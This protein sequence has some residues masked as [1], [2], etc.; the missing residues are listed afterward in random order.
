MQSHTIASISLLLITIVFCCTPALSSSAEDAIRKPIHREDH[1]G[2]HLQHTPALNTST[3]A[4]DLR[5]LLDLAEIISKLSSYQVVFIGEN[6]PRYDQ[7]LSQLAIIRGL[8]AI[9]SDLVIGV[10]FVQQPLQQ[11][12]DQ[13]I[14][15]EM[16]TREFLDKIEY[17]DRW[18]YDFRLYAPIFEFARAKAIPMLALNVPTEIIQKV[19]RE[20]LK[21]LS[22]KERAQ[23]PTQ[24]DRSSAKYRQRLKKV[25]ENHPKGFGEFEA[26]YEAQ[27]VWDESMAE[28]AA[29]YMRNYPESHMV[30]LAGNG[31]LAHGVGIPER[32]SRR[33][34]K[35]ISTAVVLNGWTGIPEPGLAD[36]LL[37]SKERE[38]P[39]P[40]FLGVMLELSD[41][42]LMISSF[43]ENSAAK[44]AGI[45]EGDELLSLNGYAVSDIADVKE[46]MW[47]KKPGEVVFV[48]V[49]RDPL[50]GKQEE[51]KFKIELR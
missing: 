33:L 16:S 45:K 44:A 49:G 50:R 4:V 11:Y 21:G 37:F 40:G 2:T 14:V 47:D 25:Y 30:I 6:H 24:I 38:L 19:G 12:L 34:D 27:L 48:R 32:F 35:S 51:K 17:Y 46:I 42:K 36:Y 26:F 10:E 3:R 8:Y 15:G 18:R 9:H 28:R 31:H 39:E 43:S 20:G 23:L 22:K 29:S 1:Q 7:H 41:E 13:Y 5:Q